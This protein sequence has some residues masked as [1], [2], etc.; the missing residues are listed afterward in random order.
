M[1]RF[2][3]LYML[4]LLLPALIACQK[5]T[6]PTPSTLTPTPAVRATYTATPQP[7]I[8]VTTPT[9]RPTSPVAEPSS[10]GETCPARQTP[11]LP[12]RP[13]AFEAYPATL[14]T[15]LNAGADPLTL[16]DV[17]QEW[18]AL[19]F[20]GEALLRAD[21]TGDGQP[22]TVLVLANPIAGTYPPASQ[23]FIFSCRAGRVE[24]LYHHTTDE[25][26]G[27]AVFAAEDLTQDGIADLLWAEVLCGASTCFYTTH[28]GSWDGQTLAERIAAPPEI[29]YAKYEIRDGELYIGSDGYGSLAAGPQRPPTTVWRWNGVELVQ[30]ETILPPIQFRYHQFLAGESALAA[31]QLDEARLAYET[32]ITSTELLPW[33]AYTDSDTEK[34]WLS[35]LARWRLMEVSLLQGERGMA[36]F[37]YQQ[38]QKEIPADSPAQAVVALARAFWEAQPQDADV[39]AACEAV[40]AQPRSAEVLAFLNG[41]GTANPSYGLADLCPVL[42]E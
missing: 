35:A 28:V 1:K 31:N 2:G 3:G 19:P 22:E 42:R 20:I 18:A 30:V 15:Y 21:L 23:M 10:A 7:P 34:V 29:P 32:T 38:L 17:A 27:A 41:F 33:A 36:S 8:T 4:L 40:R 26:T 13:A 12:S 37:H 25:W 9:P 11:P 24:L 14:L 5:T 39:A 16:T 6:P